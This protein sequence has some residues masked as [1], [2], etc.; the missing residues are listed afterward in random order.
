[1]LTGQNQ[2]FHSGR[3]RGSDN[4]IG[5]KVSGIKDGW[6]FIPVAPFFVGEGINCEMEESVELNL[7]PTKLPRRG[8]R[9]VR[10][11]W[12]NSGGRA[13]CGKADDTP[14]GKYDGD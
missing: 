11:W 1:M 12:S 10:R 5:I 6:S 8:Y 14:R 2:P 4:L 13:K 3:A 7:V 9:A